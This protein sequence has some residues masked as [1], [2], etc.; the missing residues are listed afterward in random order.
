MVKRYLDRGIDTALAAIL[1][2]MTIV[3]FLQVFFRYV[4]NQPLSWPEETARVMIV[5]LSFIGAYLAMREKKHIGFNLLVKN[6]PLR[7]QAIVNIIGRTLVIV[8]LLVV[9]KQGLFFA[10]KYLTM[11]MPYTG[12]SVGWFVYSVFPVS[13]LLM[14]FQAV[15]DLSRSFGMLRQGEHHAAGGE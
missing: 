5:W 13:G 10:Q 11:R 9:I 12:I 6:L 14:F 3:V 8:F 7:W 2:A 4:L 15:S 1:A